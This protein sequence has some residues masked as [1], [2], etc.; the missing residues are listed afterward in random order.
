MFE[1]FLA[2]QGLLQRE[3]ARIQRRY[4]FRIVDANRD[5]ARVQR[6]LRKRFAAM[7]G[8]PGK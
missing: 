8:I 5:V 2:Y 4:G 6:E 1:S 7:L 3:F